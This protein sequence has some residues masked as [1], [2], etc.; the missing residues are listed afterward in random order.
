MKMTKLSIIMVAVVALGVFGLPTMLSVGTGQH[1]FTTVQSGSADDVKA[2]CYR[3]HSASD[4]VSAEL[5]QSGNGPLLSAGVGTGKIHNSQWCGDCHALS[6]GYAFDIIQDQHAAILPSCLKCHSG[7]GSGAG[8]HD[9]TPELAN[10]SEAHVNFVFATDNDLQC[11]ACHTAVSKTGAITY[12]YNS[13][14]TFGA[15]FKIGQ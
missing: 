5:L 10:S 15:N 1:N 12:T 9:V 13:G 6:G 3:C 2:F 7:P 8:L 14:Q 11:I 4:S